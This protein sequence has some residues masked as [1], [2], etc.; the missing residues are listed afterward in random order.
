MKRTRG[1][2]CVGGA[3]RDTFEQLWCV[4]KLAAW[5]D[6]HQTLWLNLKHVHG[7]KGDVAL[8]IQPLTQRKCPDCFSIH[9]K[10]F[11]ISGG[12]SS[13]VTANGKRTVVCCDKEHNSDAE[14]FTCD[15]TM[16]AVSALHMVVVSDVRVNSCY[17]TI[18]D[19]SMSTGRVKVK[20]F[21]AISSAEISC[22]TC[23]VTRHC[24][25]HVQEQA[26]AILYF[27]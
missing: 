19:I 21:V 26:N 1:G 20:S 24:T 4:R 2:M 16:V 23:V 17:G 11:R 3:L 9:H 10:T 15:N 12:H 18:V 5:T 13:D 8:P 14:E 27:F 22:G 25:S 7:A 6:M